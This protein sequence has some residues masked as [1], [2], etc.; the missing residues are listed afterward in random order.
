VAFSG[1]VKRSLR[2]SV[3]DELT[4]YRIGEMHDML[5]IEWNEMRP[6]FRKERRPV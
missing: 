6:P 5:R 4:C 1:M 3:S 2:E